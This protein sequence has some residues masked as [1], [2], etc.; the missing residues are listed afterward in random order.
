ML[1][2]GVISL[3]L[4]TAPL[5]GQEDGKRQASVTLLEPLSNTCPWECTGLAEHHNA[6]LTRDIAFHQVLFKRK[7]AGIPP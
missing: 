2:D 1:V 5:D 3:S 4:D 6:S 7:S